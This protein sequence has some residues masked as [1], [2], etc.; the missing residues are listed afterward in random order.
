MKR[1][2]I[3]LI[4]FILTSLA[5]HAQWIDDPTTDQAIQRGIA[6]TYNLEFE[7]AQTEF[8]TVLQAKPDHPA[9]KFF[10]AMVEWW[11]ILIDIDDES[12]DEQFYDKLEEVIDMCDERLD[13]NERD[14]TGLFFKGGA[15]GFRGRLLATRKSWFKAADDGKDALPIVHDAA[16][17]APKNAD[18]LLGIGI[19]NYYAAVL[20]E[21]YPVLKPI[22]LLFPKGDKNKGIEYLKKAAEGARYANFESMYFLVQLLYSYE[23]APSQALQY[24]TRLFELFPRNA[25]FHA[26]LGRCNVRLG[27]WKEVG[28][29]F[30]EMLK[31]CQANQRGYGKKLEREA[32]YYLGFYYLTMKRYDEAIRFF[33]RCDELSRSLD[34]E[35]PSSWMAMTNLKMGFAFDLQNKRSYAVKQYDKVL[36]MK[37]H[38]NSHALARKY[39]KQPYTM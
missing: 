32:S 4:A 39:K 38:E 35:G 27:K 14:L 34:R 33:V 24:D 21:K 23:N 31:R 6:F 13:K 37:E 26:Y 9:G 17:I 15:I 2:L 11:R 28:E 36:A 16:A 12:R 1:F 7:K 19:Y 30:G 25:I 22:M 8:R 20:P 3:F 5:L 18:V 10:L 29:I